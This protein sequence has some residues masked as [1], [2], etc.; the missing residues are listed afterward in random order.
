MP[1]LIVQRK[2]EEGALEQQ[3]FGEEEFA[4]EHDINQYQV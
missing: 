4:K 1:H 2:K 3:G